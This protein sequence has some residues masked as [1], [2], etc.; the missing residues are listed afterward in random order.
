MTPAY[1]TKIEF[2]MLNW[3]TCRIR[4]IMVVMETGGREG[5]MIG[6]S[7]VNLKENAKCSSSLTVSKHARVPQM[8][9][10]DRV[11]IQRPGTG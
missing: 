3:I 6:R 1:I 9:I 5:F 10:Q 11:W 8:E 2:L 7:K 4:I